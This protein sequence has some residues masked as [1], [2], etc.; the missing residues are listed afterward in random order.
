MGIKTITLK[1]AAVKA[2]NEYDMYQ[3]QYA[4]ENFL[5]CEVELHE[6]QIN[7]S[8]DV[9]QME[10]FSDMRKLPILERYHVLL[11]IFRLEKDAKVIQFSMHPDNLYADMNYL[12]KIMMRDIYDEQ[13]T[14]DEEMF[15]QS[16]KSLVGYMLQSKYDYE[17]FFQGGMRLLE[18]HKETQA[19]ANASTLDELYELLQKQYQFLK[20]DHHEN[21][22][23][24]DRTA[25][26]RTVYLKTIFL[27]LLVM[28]ILISGYLSFFKV[29]QMQAVIR[30]NEYYITSDYINVIESLDS[31]RISQMNTNSKYILAVSYI[32]G[33][34]LSEDQKKTILSTILPTSDDRLFAYWIHSGRAQMEE[35]IDLAKQIGNREYLLYAYM[36]EK[37]LVESNTKLSGE[38]RETKL[39][40]LQQQIKTISEELQQDSKKTGDNS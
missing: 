37:S 22:I 15:F 11:N 32:K 29:P 26:K 6:D 24:V 1:K 14:Y 4:G 21:K 35:A 5:P 16:C 23:E 36:K 9:H 10:T 2:A 17:D 28:G 20:K 8:F 18:K 7:F 40:S 27:V 12:P 33:E 3:L 25:F 39:N 31:I 30:A 34:S 19:Y 38:E 13:E